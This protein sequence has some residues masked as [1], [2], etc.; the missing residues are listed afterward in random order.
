MSQSS[1]PPLP[2]EVPPV[3]PA[4]IN[5]FASRRHS[6]D[7]LYAQLAKYE[8]E[9]ALYL[10]R[11]A[12]ELNPD[13]LTARESQA[14]LALEVAALLRRDPEAEQALAA[15][16]EQWRQLLDAPSIPETV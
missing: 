6:L 16:I 4:T 1:P 13:D 8:P 12:A 11:R 3:Q 2:E 9:L 15:T 5:R 14:R 10:R 7:D